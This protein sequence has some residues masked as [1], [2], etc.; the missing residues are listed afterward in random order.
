MLEIKNTQNKSNLSITYINDAST[1]F[2]HQKIFKEANLTDAG[3]AECM[4]SLFGD[5]MRYCNTRKK[6]LTWD[7]I[8]WSAA[9]SGVP[10]MAAVAVAR[11]RHEAANSVPD[12][13]SRKRL[14]Q[15]ALSS[16]SVKRSS[17]T[18]Q[19]AQ[20]LPQFATSIEDYD[21]NPFLATTPNGTLDLHEVRFKPSRRED[22]L[23]MQLGT[24]YDLD[25]D[26]PRWKQFL[27][28]VFVDEELISYIQRAVGYSLTGDT[29]EQVVFLCHGSGANGKSVFLN[30]L[31]D[32]LGDYSAVATFDTFDANNRSG[33]S[34][35]LAALVGKRLVTVSEIE[36]NKRLAEA[37]IKSL[38]GGDLITC[39][40][41]HKEFF[42]YRPQFKI[43]MAMNHL[44]N[45]RGNDVGIWRRVHLIPFEQ[46]FRGRED[47]QLTDKLRSEMAGIL[48]WALEG[49]RMWQKDELGT[50]TAV[51]KAIE[52]YRTDCDSVGQWIGE[53][54]EV[55]AIAIMPAGAGYEDYKRWSF[56]RGEEP[57]SQ[58]SWSSS[59][60]LRGY[61]K[62]RRNK[63]QIFSG[64]GLVAGAEV[65][66]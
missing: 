32:L 7:G 9:D 28:E 41:L 59:M 14:T 57:L 55:S 43:W 45:I 58:K 33:N 22:M 12:F 56:Q 38:T 44:P 27:R 54:A 50:P 10:Q 20:A 25:A 63:G 35:D 3:N 8:K 49:L 24:T 60:A 48:N 2:A 31:G 37:K 17:D 46:S 34:N 23:T 18:L 51:A 47:R 11:I 6:W 62:V 52:S 36:E 26:A 29:S 66:G 30:V 15:W 13:E 16:E 53:R 5:F 19:M 21:Q 42:T 39:R 40:F 65:K 1:K 64:I 4:V 61:Q